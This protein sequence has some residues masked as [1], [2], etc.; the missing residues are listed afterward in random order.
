MITVWLKRW[1]GKLEQMRHTL[2]GSL[3]HRLLGE[4]IFHP[5]IWGFDV[6]SLANGFS[7][8]LFIAFTP[9]IPFQMLLSTIAVIAL[10]VNLP[11]ALAACWLTNPVTAVPVFLAAHKL[12]QYLLG[13]ATLT[14]SFLTLFGVETRTGFFMENSL[15]LWAG[16][17]IFAIAAA[18]AGNIVIR[19]VWLLGRW[20]KHRVIHHDDDRII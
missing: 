18:V 8:G 2:K 13:N 10:R 1:R 12:G 6:N 11:I 19:A 4:R 5:H 20:L 16:S 9:T 17:L 3:V 15:Y 14:K 7:A